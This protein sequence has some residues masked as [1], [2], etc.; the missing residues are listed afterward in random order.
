MTIGA[1]KYLYK[2]IYKGHDCADVCIREQWHRD[3]IDHYLS[4]R[5]VLAMEATWNNF[6]FPLQHMSH[7]AERLPVHEFGL[8]D[9]VFEE[10]CEEE[11][12]ENASRGTS[13]LKRSFF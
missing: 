10:G 4:K 11:A 2:Y 7:S 3:E 6:L 8:E 1:I 13:S 12:L 9:V 5:Y